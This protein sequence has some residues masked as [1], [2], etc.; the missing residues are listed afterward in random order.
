MKHL[1]EF[2]ERNRNWTLEKGYQCQINPEDNWEFPSDLWNSLFFFF[3]AF[4]GNCLDMEVGEG[5]EETKGSCGGLG[6][7]YIL[8]ASRVVQEEVLMAV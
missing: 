1:A 7:G 3:F 2:T 6:L 4:Q 8:L 5:N